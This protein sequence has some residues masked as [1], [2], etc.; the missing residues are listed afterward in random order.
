MTVNEEVPISSRYFS[1]DDRIEIADGLTSGEPVRSIA[2]R[3]GKS[4]QSVY[5]EIGRNRKPDGTYQPWFAPSQ[6]HLKRRRPKS[7]V[8]EYDAALRQVVAEKLA[9]RWSPGQISRWLRRCHP[10]KIGWHV[11]VETLYDAVYRGLIIGANP[12]RDLCTNR[13]YRHRRGRGRS[14]G[15]AMKQSPAGPR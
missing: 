13:A 9:A 1:Q 6:A 5:R 3:I 10:F 7:R 11:C 14:R 12:V 4:F 2:L 15:G 8:F